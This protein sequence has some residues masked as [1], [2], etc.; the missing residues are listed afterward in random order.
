MPID[1]EFRDNVKIA[2]IRYLKDAGVSVDDSIALLEAG[3]RSLTIK[4]AAPPAAA[5]AAGG[6]MAAAGKSKGGF[7]ELGLKGVDTGLSQAVNGLDVVTA[8]LDVYPQVTSLGVNLGNFLRGVNNGDLPSNS[9]VEDHDLAME[10]E[11]ESELIRRRLAYAK[12]KKKEIQKS[13][14][15]RL[16]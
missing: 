16:F 7:A 12:Q 8:P 6:A 4:T 13:S 2:C 15:R 11:L 1:S 3:A 9:E 14:S 5:L 10:Y